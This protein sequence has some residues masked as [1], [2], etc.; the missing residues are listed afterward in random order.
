MNIAIILVEVG[1]VIFIFS[2]FNW[3]I[4]IT[5]KQIVKVSWLNER[6]EKIATLRRNLS[7]FLIFLC[8]V[9]CLLLIGKVKPGKHLH[10]QRVLRKILKETFSQEE[11]EIYGFSKDGI[12]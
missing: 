12:G 7:R 3:L 8:V 9:L 6:T 10:I 1:F 11:I 4:G 5:C 2:L